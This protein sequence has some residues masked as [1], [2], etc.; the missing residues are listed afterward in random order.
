MAGI[1][2]FFE[3]ND[4]DI[5]SGRRI[6]LSAWNYAIK[7]AGDVDRVI[8]V[9]KTDKALPSIDSDFLQFEIISELPI[10]SGHVTR[11]ICPWD[12]ADIKIPLWDF[13]HNTD[14]YVFGPAGGWGRYATPSNGVYIPMAN[15]GALHSVHIASA[16]MLHRFG[17]KSWQ[18]Q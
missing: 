17:V 6:D 13:N 12:N 3:D 16:V 2:F 5:F 11:I 1:V 10:L 14:W 7:S 15:S 18:P 9:N 8:V 4:V